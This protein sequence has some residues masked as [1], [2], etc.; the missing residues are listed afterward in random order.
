MKSK[1][2]ISTLIILLALIGLNQEQ[3]KVA[4]QQIVLQFTDAETTSLTACDDA[5]ATITKKLHDLGVTGIEIIESDNVKLTIRYYS[6]ID[7]LTVGELLSQDSKLSLTYGNI[8]ELPF[9][10]PKEELPESFSLVISDLQQKTGDGLGLNGKFASQSRPDYQGFSNPSVLL[11]NDALVL[12]QALLTKVA[13]NAH[14]VI[15][16]AIDNT[17]HIIPEVRAGPYAC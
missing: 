9:D 7:A 2:Y 12:G 1:W 3:T 13:Y 11:F 10:F 15:A 14:Q 4:N 16:I 8:G 6:D 5:L 17:S